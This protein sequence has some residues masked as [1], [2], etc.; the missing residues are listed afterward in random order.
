MKRSGKDEIARAYFDREAF[1]EAVL[2]SEQV[3]KAIKAKA[4]RSAALK[5]VRE[6][7]ASI[8]GKLSDLRGEVGDQEQALIDSLLDHAHQSVEFQVKHAPGDGP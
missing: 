6:E 1:I 8:V 7:L 2:M 4:D 3:M 5:A